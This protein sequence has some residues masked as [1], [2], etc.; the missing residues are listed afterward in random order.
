MTG[1]AFLLAAIELFGV[2]GEG[3]SARAFFDAN[4]VKVGDPLVL[5]VDFIG[6]ADFA[7]L[8]PPAL[9]QAVDRRD[10]KV[11][12]ASA[13]T[14]TYSSARRLVYRVRPMR[15]G[16]L[17]FPRLEFV[18]MSPSGAKLSVESNEIPVHAKAGEQVAVEE[19]WQDIGKLPDPDGLA[20]EPSVGLGDD[21]MFA[22]RKAC[23]SP[24]AEAFAQFD[25]PEARMN[26][27]RCATLAGEWRKAL[28][29]YS[30]LEWKT[31]Q[32]P[33]I[34][35]GIVAAL[36][37][38]YGSA[39]AELPVW[40][41]VLRPVLKY[42]WKMRISLIAG[43]AVL[44]LLLFRVLGRLVR[45][46]AAVA[47]VLAFVLPPVPASADLVDEIDRMHREMRE[48]MHQ[49]M[50]F[51]FGEEENSVTLDISARAYAEPDDLQVG[52]RFEFIIEIDAPKNVTLENLSVRPGETFGM[53]VAGKI[54]MLTDAKSANPSN[55]VHRLALPVR[56]DVP[57]RGAVPFA[58]E[59]MASGRRSGG[60]RR[61]A[62]SISF[63][64]SFRVEAK[65]VAIDVKPLSKDGQPDDF[66][67]IVSDSLVFSE[68]TD[69]KRVETNDVIQITYSLD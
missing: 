39:D 8:H 32:T 43:A 20:L 5:T 47:A 11:D 18:Y 60:R 28:G 50:G 15:E 55:P 36:A 16:V 48:Q 56:Y 42:G 65:P 7:S 49:M 33:A 30:R 46:L 57:F 61:G 64:N 35:R 63:S 38:K 2:V 54:E 34:E 10:W 27:A 1:S 52:E 51:S 4:N 25:F 31:G 22:W 24:S 9:S 62:F 19:E 13:K 37:R 45:A 12:D 14:D 53:T 59:G 3:I 40:R 21:E 23:A 17:W 6:E 68:R 26:E 41:Q 44:A 69:L 67:G 66:A 29:I 58:V